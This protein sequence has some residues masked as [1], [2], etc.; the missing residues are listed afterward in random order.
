MRFREPGWRALTI[1]LA[2]MTLSVCGGG[3]KAGSPGG[4]TVPVA[5]S[6]TPTPTPVAEAPL[7]ASCQK[8]PPASPT[9][10]TCQTEAPTFRA[11]VLDALA[12]LR[13][14]QPEIF[15]GDRV[16]N[17]GAYYVGLIRILDRKG[18]CADFDG[19][20]L[21]VTNTPDYNDQYDVLTGRNEVRPAFFEGTCYPSVVPIPR[22]PLY[23]V[24]AGCSLSA[25]REIVCGKEAEGR[26]HDDVETT[27]DEVLR[28]KPELFDFSQTSPGTAWPRI[29]D[30][31]AYHAALVAG[32]SK[33][34]YC[35]LFDGEEIE[36]KRTNAFSEHYDLNL[37]DRYVRRGPGSYQSICYPAAF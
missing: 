32:L 18:L 23:G 20:E 9:P 27:L 21:G 14:E 30:L 29:R 35:A 7:S 28:D 22:S 13:Q 33:K 10:N 4:P 2:A 12:T 6:P 26:Y 24:P 37:A 19:D 11:D 31:A 3:G 34:G 17:V 15:D 36:V 25:S 5:P 8:L 1:V 16:L